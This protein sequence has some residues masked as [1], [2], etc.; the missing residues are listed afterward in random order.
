MPSPS[1]K[2]PLASRFRD[3]RVAP[4]CRRQPRHR[5]PRQAG[6]QRE[7]GVR[8][9]AAAV[10]E[11]G[12]HVEPV[13]QRGRER[14]I[15]MGHR[16]RGRT[17]RIDGGNRCHSRRLAMI[18]QFSPIYRNEFANRVDIRL[19]SRKSGRRHGFRSFRSIRKHGWKLQAFFDQEVLPRHRAWLAH[20]AKGEVA[21][22]M[23][24]LQSKAR[25]A[26]L[27]NS[28]FPT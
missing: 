9:R 7:V 15:G 19:G 24:D 22:F 21:P 10:A 14:G 11:R 6:M 5:R 20:V 25:A 17:G 13:R 1:W 2:R 23:G 8:Q 16:R 4:A 28:A 26:G 18:G 27:W 12:Q 3:S